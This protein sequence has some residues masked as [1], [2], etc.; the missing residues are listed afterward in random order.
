[1][2]EVGQIVTAKIAN[3]K[4]YGFFVVFDDQT[5]LVHITEISDSYIED[6]HK[7]VSEN[8]IVRLK[9][10]NIKDGKYS[11]SFKQTHPRYNANFRTKLNENMVHSELIKQFCDKEIQ[12]YKFEDEGEK[13]VKY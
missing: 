4:S 11:L 8:E 6:I 3:I 10:I 7:I 13:H 5:G 1:M 9:I 12:R 2:Y